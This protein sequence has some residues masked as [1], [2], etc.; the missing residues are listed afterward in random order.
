MNDDL[1]QQKSTLLDQLSHSFSQDRITLEEYERL[2]ESV[3][4]V[5]SSTELQ[6]LSRSIAVYPRGEAAQGAAQ[7][8]HEEHSRGPQMSL[9]ILSGSELKGRFV[10]SRNHRAIAVLGGVD[11]DLRYAEI[12]A[13]GI[14][15]E[16]FAV[17][18]GVEITVPD[19]LNVVTR[20]MG[21]LGGFSG[22][23]NQSHIPGAPVVRVRGLALLGG[24]EIKVRK[25]K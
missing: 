19:D 5:R 11:I 14:D 22:G 24:V 21:I 12:P 16:A 15:I 10:A 2:V 4:S 13:E 9:A 23:N 7:Y 3:A 18:G 8:S 25:R 1:E 6:T 20:G 17:L